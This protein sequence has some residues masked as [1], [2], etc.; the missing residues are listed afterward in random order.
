MTVGTGAEQKAERCIFGCEH[1]AEKKLELEKRYKISNLPPLMGH[2]QQGHTSQTSPNS[3]TN[4]GP[5]SQISELMGNIFYSNHHS[6]IWTQAN[7]VS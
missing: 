3:A 2:L 5:T 6:W 1:E 4:G 7:S